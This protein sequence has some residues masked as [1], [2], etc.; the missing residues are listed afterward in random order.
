MKHDSNAATEAPLVLALV[1]DTHGVFDPQLSEL[2][3]DASLVLH[4]GDVGHHGLHAGLGV[5]YMRGA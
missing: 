5:C 4:A 3:R 2:L 1:S